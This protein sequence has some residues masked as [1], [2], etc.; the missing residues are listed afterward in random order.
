M[1]TVFQPTQGTGLLLLLPSNSPPAKEP[2]LQLFQHT[3][4]VGCDSSALPWHGGTAAHQRDEQDGA[5][6]DGFGE[7]D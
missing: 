7:G 1:A 6:R 4:E 5:C 3:P 2:T